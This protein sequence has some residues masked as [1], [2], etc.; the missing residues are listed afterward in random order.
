MKDAR[1]VTWRA[2]QRLAALG[3]AVV[4]VLI[5]GPAA[6]QPRRIELLSE[7]ARGFTAEGRSEAPAVNA[8]GLVGAYSSDAR[9]LLSP[10]V[11]SSLNQM[12]ARDIE[13]VTSELVSVPAEGRIGN[14]P[15]QN[16]G[17]PP[18]ISGDGRFVTFSSSASNLVEEDIGGLENVFVY[19]RELD[20]MELISR[21]PDMPANGASNFP[22]ISGDGRYVVFQ[23]IASNLVD[24]DTNG[25]SDIYCY[26][27]EE[28]VMILVTVGLDSASN[29]LSITP[30]ISADG[31]WIAYASR[32]TNLVSEPT[33]GTFEQIF[34]TDWDSMTTELVSVSSSGN[35]GNAISFLPALS[36]DGSQIAFKSEAF[37][38][39]PNDTMGVPDV[40]VRDRTDDTT[41]RVSV[42]DF[43]N[44]A[45]GLSGGPGISGDGRF[46]A[47][48]SFASNLLI[49]DGN[50]FSD[51]YVY[52]RFPPGREMGKIRRVT[53][54]IDGQ[55]PNQGVSDF[56]V[57][58]STDGR[59]VGFASSASNL[60]P[61]DLN[62]DLDA[63][64]GCNPFD[65]FECAPPT[66]VPTATPTE[67]PGNP[68]CVGDCNGDGQVTVDDLIR[69]IN[70]ALE[71][72][73]LCPNGGLGC[74][75]GDANCDCRITVDEIVRAV[76]NALQ[77]CVEFGDCTVEQIEEMCCEEPIG[78]PTNT[79]TI[80]P[81]PPIT[82]TPTM[83]DGACVGD[84]NGNGTVTIDDLIRMVSIALEIQPIC[85]EGGTGGCLAGDANCNCTITVDELI[86][87]VNNVLGGC[88]IFNT[89][90][91]TQQEEMCCG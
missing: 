47:F 86:Q 84:C 38:L 87:A 31:R 46:V 21:G 49:D 14:Q 17:F 3:L 1:G 80:T 2:E 58:M 30:N 20:Q 53:V 63:F 89:C 25:L 11:Q 15:S 60:V 13:V 51:I 90:N 78:T 77:G 32:A 64:L 52:D 68:P 48:P 61:N 70:I 65:E 71:L 18:G 33:T 74:L 40:F 62:N 82:P 81:T 28:D 4:A 9:D 43:G 75:A 36:A 59:W 23:S 50:G 66:P 5:A 16:S 91:P 76:Q 34:V 85:P 7:T 88:T 35:P 44:Q 55:E 79:R 6:A 41:Q 8:N 39:V 56:P 72:A 83:G 19:D 29:G 22:K 54:G 12:Y 67:T 26:D 57:T 10:P 37:N 24:G 27:R 73:P 42:D 45:N 69:M